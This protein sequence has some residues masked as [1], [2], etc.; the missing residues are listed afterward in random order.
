[1]SKRVPCK[2]C[3]VEVAGGALL[4]LKCGVVNPGVHV[5]RG[6][7]ILVGLI[8]VLF[9]LLATLGGIDRGVGIFALLMGAA[10]VAT[11]IRSKT[12]PN[13]SLRKVEV[14]GAPRYEGRRLLDAASTV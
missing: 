5:M 4:C 2:A 8:I 3:G 1:M 13:T 7:A 11:A 9:G 12:K 14:H 10:I 6:I